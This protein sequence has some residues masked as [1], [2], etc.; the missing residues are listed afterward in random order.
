[1]SPISA[2]DAF[3]IVCPILEKQY[4]EAHASVLAKLKMIK[5]IQEANPMPERFSKAWA[6]IQARSPSEAAAIAE[7]MLELQNLLDIGQTSQLW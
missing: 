2:Q 6:S 4:Q 1:M 7:L 3:G 5:L